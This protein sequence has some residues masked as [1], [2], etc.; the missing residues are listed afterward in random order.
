MTDITVLPVPPGHVACVI[1]HMQMLER[2]PIRPATPPEGARIERVERPDPDWYRALF[3][4]VG[5]A[6]IWSSR[7]EMSDADLTAILH[8]PEVQVHALMVDG[9]AE[10]L[11]EL[12]FRTMG[13]C[14]LKFFGVSGPMIGTTAARALMNLAVI[15]AWSRP[16]TRFWVH[17]CTF[18]DQKAVPFYMRSGFV[19]YAR[20]FE[21]Q[22]DPRLKGLIPE[23]CAPQIPLV[24]P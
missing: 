13:E 11:M 10:G 5:E 9:Q 3:R 14:E 7:L 19:P 24:R 22:P 20:E 17:T 18:D 12:D 2:A 4:R 8:D 16:I 1:T 15:L 23:H 21:H 6:Y